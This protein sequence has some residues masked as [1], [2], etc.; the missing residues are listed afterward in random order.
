[1]RADRTLASIV[2]KFGPT[3]LVLLGCFAGPRA[4]VAQ[5]ESGSVSGQ[6]LDPAGA[7]VAHARITVRNASTTA[8][9]VTSSDDAGF[10]SA[11]QLA[12]GTYTITATAP[13][14]STLVQEGIVVR[15]NDRLK[16]DLRLQVG[17]VAETVRVEATTPL[18][19]TE[20][21]TAGQVIENQRITELPLNGRNWL[22]LATL[23]PATVTY[24]TIVDGGTGNSQAVLMNLGG[25]RT[26]QNNYL[27]NGVD[28]TV[29]VS[30]G[31]AVVYPPVDA[32]QEFKVQTNNYTADTGRLA[33]AVVNATIKSG[34]NAW[35]GSA[36]EFLR[37]RSLNARNFF[38]SPTQ[39]KP[40]F[41]RNQFGAS[42]GGPFIRNK[43]FFF[44]NYEGNRQ[45]QDQVV[46]R[47]VFTAAQK[48]GDFAGQLGGQIGTDALGRPVL[49]GQIFD[50]FSVRRLPNG[51]AIRDAFPGNVIPA[52]R[53]NPVSKQLI[54][55][56]PSPNSSGTPNFVRNLSAP[57]NIDTFAGESTWCIRRRIQ[58]SA[59][60]YTPTSTAL[61]RR[62]SDCRP[63]GATPR[64]T[65]LRI[66][67][68]SVSGGRTC[69]APGI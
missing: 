39:S 21:A 23:A 68:S 61:R 26:T 58:C 5:Q 11:P 8:V 17:A 31:G 69:L 44:L 2:L 3:A 30:S 6:I 67:G 50:P 51:T 35:H 42:I 15:V 24:P 29:F 37:N 9:F 19:Q 45:R 59:I 47:Q 62:F 49:S 43:L 53:L 34:S 40:Q 13:G 56:V 4:A 63:T 12:P 14:F 55:L 20:D 66:S 48:A 38:A 64:T 54:D 1:M 25:T 22:Q 33:G 57:L 18:L 41:T 36:Y 7:L 10:Y 52:S 65:L 28:N 16:I 60:S 27:L 32:L 46:T